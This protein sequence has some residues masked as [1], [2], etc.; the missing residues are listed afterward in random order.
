MLVKLDA[1]YQ[2]KIIFQI[3]NY[4]L[5]V[6]GKQILGFQVLNFQENKFEG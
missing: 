1:P 2:E 4:F 3:L 5:I 6:F